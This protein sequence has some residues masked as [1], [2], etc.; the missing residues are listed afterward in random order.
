MTLIKLNGYVPTNPSQYDLTLTDI[1][2]EKSQVED[3]TTFVE[4][5]RKNVP[6]INVGW[7]NLSQEKAEAITSLTSN[8]KINVEYFYGT[9][10]S[11]EMTVSDRSLKLKLIEPNGNTY[12]NLSFTLEG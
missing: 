8:D 3:G 1:N 10:Q 6:K 9:M 2:G 4:G 5:I 7:T 11:C 12:W